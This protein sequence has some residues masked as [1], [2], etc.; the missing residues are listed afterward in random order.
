MVW[1]ALWAPLFTGWETLGEPYPFLGSV[2]SSVRW[3]NNVSLSG[4][5]WACKETYTSKTPAPNSLLPAS[6]LCKNRSGWGR[7]RDKKGGFL[8]IHSKVRGM[9]T[10]NIEKARDF[11]VGCMQLSGMLIPERELSTKAGPLTVSIRK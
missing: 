11:Q 10:N 5:V 9:L 1:D 2:P 8:M 6:L 3:E 4:F 7:Q